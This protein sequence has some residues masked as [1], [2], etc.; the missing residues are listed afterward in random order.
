MNR[1]RNMDITVDAISSHGTN[2]QAKVLDFPTN[3]PFD[4]ILLTLGAKEMAGTRT[5]TPLEWNSKVV[6][7]LASLLGALVILAG[8]IWYAASLASTVNYMEK[9]T[10][11]KIDDLK[12]RLIRIEERSITDDKRKERVIGYE[13]GVNETK[14]KGDK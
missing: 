9:D 12:E 1:K 3:S 11:E 2:G 14:A 4:H 6:A 8:V 5:S 13:M 7:L 10:K